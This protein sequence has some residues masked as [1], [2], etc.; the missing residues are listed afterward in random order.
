[1]LSTKQDLSGV[2]LSGVKR[3]TNNL[4]PANINDL[5]C[6]SPDIC[7]VISTFI[8]VQAKRALFSKSDLYDPSVIK[9]L[10]DCKGVLLI[11][12]FEKEQIFFFHRC[13]V[14]FLL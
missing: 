4:I 1:M 3:K 2:Q 8:Y 9:I 5:K 13:N 10:I 12:M 14:L 6:I 7:A 11:L